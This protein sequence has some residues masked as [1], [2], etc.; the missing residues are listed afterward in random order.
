M[1]EAERRKLQGWAAGLVR[2]IED[3]RDRRLRSL[4]QASSALVQSDEA[5]PKGAPAKRTRRRKKRGPNAA[6]LAERRR[7][8]IYRFL[9]EQRRPLGFSEIY[10]S[11]RLSEFSTRSALKR[12]VE[13]KMVIRT[14]TG[15]ATRYE[16]RPDGS[17][18]ST[19]GSAPPNDQGTVQGRLLA[20]IEDRGSAS[21]D[22]LAQAVGAPR[23]EVQRECGALIREE[24]IRMARR[25]G[26]AVYVSQRAA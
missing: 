20:T 1:L 13:E 14:G 15:S 24:E 5:A 23:E 11:L 25:D 8:A 10:R 6:V 17:G 3:Q 16:A 22:E 18:V 4:D 2:D 12:L 7:H 26:R 19:G 9:V 21:V